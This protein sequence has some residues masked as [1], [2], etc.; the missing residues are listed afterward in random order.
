[1]TAFHTIRLEP[2][3]GLSFGERVA[4]ETTTALLWPL[5]NDD[6]MTV[7]INLMAAQIGSI[8]ENEDQIDAIMDVLRMQLKLGNASLRTERADERAL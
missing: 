6:R 5:Q 2:W 1:M 8:V 4:L 7:L 3:R